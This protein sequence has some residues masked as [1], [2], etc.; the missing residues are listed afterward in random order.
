MAAIAVGLQLIVWQIFKLCRLRWVWI[1]PISVI[2][3]VLLFYYVFIPQAYKS[4]EQ[5]KEIVTYDY[6]VRARKW[7]SILAYS[8]KHEPQTMCGI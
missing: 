1:Y 6:L 4:D 2:P 5:F 7:K 8:Y 3:S